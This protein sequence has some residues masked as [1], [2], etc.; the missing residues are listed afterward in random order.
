MSYSA[1]QRYCLNIMGLVAWTR[2][3]RA[4]GQAMPATPTNV[5]V[6]ET[7]AAEAKHPVLRDCA[8]HDCATLSQ[9][10]VEQPLVPFI[11]RGNSVSC[12]GSEQA[13]LAVVCLYRHEMYNEVT[14]A[15]PLAQDC[16]SL[17]NQ[18]MR[19]IELPAAAFRQCVIRSPGDNETVSETAPAIPFDRRGEGLEAVITPTVKAVLV[20]DDVEQWHD[21]DMN[22]A[23]LPG[24]ALP[25]WRIPH[26]RILLIDTSLKR[27]AWENL[28]ALKQAL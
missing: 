7:L 2:V 23:P 15:L 8:S 19:A 20:L 28:K 4:S 6:G 9:W 3:H 27:R 18:M 11:Y 16:E 17:L 1:R 14:P 21:A 13:I 24:S 25:V 5:A 22:D 10:L 26:P 12:I